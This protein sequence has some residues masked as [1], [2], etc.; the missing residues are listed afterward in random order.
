LD[1]QAPTASSTTASTG[2]PLA[3]SNADSATGGAEQQGA[4]SWQTTLPLGFSLRLEHQN[5]HQQQVH[6]AAIDT[7]PGSEKKKEEEE[8]GK[9]EPGNSTYRLAAV[10]STIRDTPRGSEHLVI[11]VRNPDKH[12]GGGGNWLLFNDF[13][14]QPVSEESVVGLSDWW[15]APTVAL[16]ASADRQCLADALA[17]IVDKYP[18]KISTRILT[19]PTSVL[20]RAAAG[21][22]RAN[23]SQPGGYVP[24]RNQAVPLT[25]QEAELME[26]GQFMCAFDAEF[27][28][29]E[30]AK[31][32]VFSDGTQQV[33]QPEIHTLARLSIVR[34]SGG[35]LHGVPFVDDYVETTRPIAD[36]ATQYSGIH[37]GDLTVGTSPYK[38][39]T[40]KEVYK[41]LQL[42]VD[43]GCII[44]GHGLK[45][46]F[47]VCNIVVPAAQQRDTMV[48]FQSP[49]HIRPIALR[50]LY[51]FFYQKNVQTGEHSSVE[52]AQTALKVFESYRRC[53]GGDGEYDIG[54]I[55]DI[56]DQIYESGSK[57]AWKTQDT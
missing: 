42:L 11:H 19:H 18:Y 16:Y 43:C 54:G 45:H 50:F 51:W 38:L 8:E 39:S 12:D 14:V 55:E 41:K 25:K 29:L 28:V 6:V 32:E 46:D 49:H 4:A 27:V 3:G 30:A 17:A 40:M 22:R 26:K 23:S 34:A 37:A 1:L 13:L 35:T 2:P 21:N 33:L 48:L 20:D 10:I 47:R 24:N 57:L 9:E 5:K 7:G 44:I 36:L 53:V 52:D 15:R 31:T 56:L